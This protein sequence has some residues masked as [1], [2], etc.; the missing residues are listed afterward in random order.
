MLRRI[1]IRNGKKYIVNV[2][3]HSDECPWAD[4]VAVWDT[5]SLAPAID[6]Y[7]GNLVL[8]G[9]S[10]TYTNQDIIDV[11]GIINE[12]NNTWKEIHTHNCTSINQLKVD[13]NQL[14]TIDII[15]ASSVTLLQCFQNQLSSIDLTQLPSLQICVCNNNNITNLDF[16]TN[17]DLIEI[18]AYN[19]QLT[20]L[21]VNNCPNLSLLRCENNQLTLLDLSGC[22]NFDP[23]STFLNNPLISLNIS[24]NVSMGVFNLSSSFKITALTNLIAENTNISNFD[25]SNTNLVTL[26]VSGSLSIT[27]LACNN[28]NLTT[29][30]A[31][32]TSLS[33]SSATAVKLQNNPFLI[34]FSASNCALTAFPGT[35]TQLNNI[36]SSIKYID[37]SENDITATNVNNILRSLHSGSLVSGSINLSGGTNA[38]PTLTGNAASA[39]LKAK[40]WTVL[41]N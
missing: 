8:L 33:P 27:N 2:P 5:G 21:N 22:T 28:N 1:I 36:T 31:S 40:H 15:S 30:N 39:S 14:T 7:D 13:N 41:A 35:I 10:K 18:Q 11:G 6:P 23:N 3:D 29:I 16:T 17:I 19:N 4:G 38:K 32:W 37:L 25:C 9:S 34:T 24:N 12:M 20:Q 26:D